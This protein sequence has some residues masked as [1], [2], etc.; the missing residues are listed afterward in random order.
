M[1]LPE[2]GWM[3]ATDFAMVH[4]VAVRAERVPF[5]YG[6]AYRAVCGQPSLPAE[7]RR[8]P[9]RRVC[10]VC[11]ARTPSSTLAA[12]VAPPDRSIW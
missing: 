6:L 2:H 3:L 8:L 7:P 1:H 5:M 10:R 9:G 11:A 12:V 4:H